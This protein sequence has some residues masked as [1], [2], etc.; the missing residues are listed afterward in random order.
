MTN[1]FNTTL[2]GLAFIAVGCFLSFLWW[3][4]MFTA[5]GLIGEVIGEA[6]RQN[7]DTCNSNHRGDCGDPGVFI[8]FIA[9]LGAFGAQAF[10]TLGTFVDGTKLI[11]RGERTGWFK[12]LT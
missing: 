12:N 5:T 10:V 2:L 9:W 1:R 8:M 11:I 6:V 7:G 3:H 4:G